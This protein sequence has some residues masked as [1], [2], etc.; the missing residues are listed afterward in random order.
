[1]N[2]VAGNSVGWSLTPNV[3]RVTM[4]G[5][6]CGGVSKLAA[7]PQRTSHYVRFYFRNDETQNTNWHPTWYNC[8]GT[9]Q[10]VPWSRRGTSQGVF[11][12]PQIARAAN[13]SDMPYPYNFWRPGVQGQGN[14]TLSN[15]T[16]YRYEYYLEYVSATGYRIYPRVYDMAGNL[17]YDVNAFFPSDYQGQGPTLAAYYAAGNAFGITDAQLATHFGMGNEGPGGASNSGQ[18]WYYARVGISL[19]G[20]VGP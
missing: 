16:W 11:I 20:W 3:M 1:M 17:L 9:I 15:G 13:G 18:S 5:T 4:L 6:Q 12:G 7:V 8:C 10:M 19:N 14:R 2:V